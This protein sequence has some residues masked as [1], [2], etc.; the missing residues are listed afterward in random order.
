MLVRENV[1]IDALELPRIQ[2]DEELELREA[3]YELVPVEDSR[4]LTVASN[5]Q[6]NRRYCKPWTREFL[7]DLSEA[8]WDEFH[9]PLMITS[10]VRTAEQQ[11]KLRRRN[12][13]AAPDEGETVSTH[14]TGMTFDLY[15]GGMSRR[16]HAWIEQYF[17]PFQQ[18]GLIEPIEERRQP[19]FHV[20]VFDG[21]SEWRDSQTV[22]EST[23]TSTTASGEDLRRETS[24]TPGSVVRGVAN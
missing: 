17:L 4:A 20:T 15:K 5:L 12:G 2:D 10:L 23:T 13:N 9:Q 8:Y 14:L 3:N 22:P 18:R 6:V 7:Q 21:Y 16:Q 19:V 11:K 1:Q 24:S